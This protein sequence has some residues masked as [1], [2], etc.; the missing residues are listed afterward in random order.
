MR[1]KT[2]TEKPIA[3]KNQFGQSRRFGNS[4]AYSHAFHSQCTWSML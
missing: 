2:K 1:K 4:K 3:V